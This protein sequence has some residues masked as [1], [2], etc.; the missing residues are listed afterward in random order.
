LSPPTIDQLEDLI[1]EAAGEPV[2][3][4]GFTRLEPW[5]V[6]RCQLRHGNQ[7]RPAI[8]KWL[9]DHPG[10]L[11]VDPRQIGT[12]G[13][14]LEFLRSIGFPCSPRLVAADHRAGVLVMEDLAPRVP[15]DGLLRREGMAAV[16]ADLNSYAETLGALGAATAGR[17]DLY[18]EVRRRFGPADPALCDERGV[19]PDWA[20]A[21]DLLDHHGLELSAS[22]ERN[23]A[24]LLDGLWRPGPFLAL[25]N[26]DPQ[27]NNFLVGDG[28]GRL[29]DFESASYRHALT[30]A[31]LL[32]VPGPAWINV[33]EPV[34]V[35]L[36]NAYRRE[37]SLGIIEADDDRRF[38]FGMAAAC[39]AYAL[40]RLTRLQVLDDRPLGDGSRL[41]MVSTLE[42]A[43]GVARR[44]R[45]LPDLAGWVMRVA[46]WLRRR[47]PDADVDLST[48]PA[49]TPR[50]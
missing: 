49:W 19:G 30:S 7:S 6:A 44:H 28:G 31:V 18:G 17:S 32:H 25:S 36:E 35:K 39:L 15:L 11:R 13:A 9:R 29:I 38:G 3:V 47:W 23:L 50:N 10:G 45:A 43:A 40:D 37:L 41:Q 5:A 8:V 20:L 48:Y 14:A 24:D 16:V 2:R 34:G 1:R 46:T 33:S 21:R 12:E 4:E 27:V 42:S 22:V 26:G